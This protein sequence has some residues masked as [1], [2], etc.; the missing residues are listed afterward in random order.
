MWD[1]G[2]GVIPNRILLL[3]TE[4]REGASALPAV[5]RF[6]LVFRLFFVR[7]LSIFFRSLSIFNVNS[8]SRASRMSVMRSVSGLGDVQL[9]SAEGRV[10]RGV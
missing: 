6:V 1:E 3:S 2:V 4:G 9:G 5:Y 8:G 10:G 7:L